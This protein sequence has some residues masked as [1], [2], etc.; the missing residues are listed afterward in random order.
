MSAHAGGGLL[1][2]DQCHGHRLGQD[3]GLLGE[4][5]GE[6][7]AGA[8]RD[9]DQPGGVSEAVELWSGQ[10]GDWW[11]QDVFPKQWSLMSRGQWRRHVPGPGGWSQA[12]D[13][14]LQ[15][16]PI[17]DWLTQYNVEF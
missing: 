5:L 3:L 1:C 9:R 2:W 8:G 17:S 6:G 7:A 14:R 4:V 16:I 10:S 11:S 12:V 15:V 13:R